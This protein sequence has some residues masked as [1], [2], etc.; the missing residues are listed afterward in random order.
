VS[1]VLAGG[2]FGAALVWLLGLQV[3]NGDRYVPGVEL[4]G[5]VVVALL[6]V[7]VVSAGWE[8]RP[9]AADVVGRA[10]P[11]FFLGAFLAVGTFAVA[12]VNSGR[13]S[14]GVAGAALEVLGIVAAT[15]SARLL[16]RRGGPRS[17]RMLAATGALSLVVIAYA[18]VP[19][20]VRTTPP[21]PDEARRV[22]PDLLEAERGLIRVVGVEVGAVDES[23]GPKGQSQ[24]KYVCVVTV[25]MLEDGFHSYCSGPKIRKT[26]TRVAESDAYN[27][28]SRSL[29]RGVSEQEIV[30]VAFW[31]DAGVG[32][33]GSDGKVH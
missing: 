30:D 15:A 12:V 18:F 16:A 9:S 22:A 20:P 3:H 8:R 23:S 2:A 29:A 6:Y 28:R 24:R 4:A 27:C 26:F 31:F 32:W 17:R 33:V 14:P 10:L 21:G 13:M 5:L 7:A 1:T 25:E 11:T 19:R